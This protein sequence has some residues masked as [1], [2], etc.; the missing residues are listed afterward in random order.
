M[1]GFA[2]SG[3]D[4]KLPEGVKNPIT[5]GSLPKNLAPK[6]HA[7]SKATHPSIKFGL[8]LASAL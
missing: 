8:F 1:N 4:F 3:K 2:F 7:E 6:Y 5:E